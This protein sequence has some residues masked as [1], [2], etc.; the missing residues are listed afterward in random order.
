MRRPKRRILLCSAFLIASLHART[1]EAAE[2][3]YC[4]ATS[5]KGHTIYLSTPFSNDAAMTEIESAFGHF[6]DRTLLRYDS[7]QC[8]RGDER[9]I[10]TMKVHAIQYNQVNGNKVVQLNWAP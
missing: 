8:P 1:T 6:L 9:S 3:R 7:I 4:L 5:S 10:A 2:W